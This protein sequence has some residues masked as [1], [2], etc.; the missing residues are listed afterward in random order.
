MAGPIRYLFWIPMF[1]MVIWLLGLVLMQSSVAGEHASKWIAFLSALTALGFTTSIWATY[2]PELRPKGISKIS[3]EDLL[4]GVAINVFLIGIAAA[5]SYL[6][7]FSK[8]ELIFKP[9]LIA[10][11]ATWSL[12]LLDHRIY[13]K[14]YLTHG[15]SGTGDDQPGSG[16]PDGD[17][18]MSMTRKQTPPEDGPGRKSK[19]AV[20]EG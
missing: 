17:N 14:Y 5:I 10:T 11:L 13:Q 4:F 20:A 9:A 15:E 3:L 1:G 16:D 7:A 12:W 19:E 8:F 18:D 2:I 6:S